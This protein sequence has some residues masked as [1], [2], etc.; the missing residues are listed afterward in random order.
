MLN[1]KQVF[2]LLF[3]TMTVLI[4]AEEPENASNPL[5]AV[6]NTDLRVKYFDLENAHGIDYYIDGATMLSPKLKLKYELH[7]WNTNISGNDEQNL[8]SISAK[9]IYFP[10]EGKIG[11][12]PYR[13]AMGT[14]WHK[15]LG[16]IDKGIG[17]DADTISV[18]FGAAMGISKNLTLIPLI[19]HY[20]SY[21]GNDFSMTAARVIAIQTL[22][23]QY[24]LKYDLK[25]PYV[26]DTK[27]VPA[28]FEFQIGKSFS[29]SFGMY[30]DLQVGLGGYKPYNTGIGLGIRY[31]Y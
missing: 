12:I 4:H 26:W 14:E 24:W 16:D 6:S 30:I 13:I 21:S 9:L 18:F 20:E 1:K 28:A 17:I 15:D 5:A 29:Q 31:N 23:S 11:D 8:E 3:S 10:K 22:P 7:Y 25:V 19:E 2:T 27:T